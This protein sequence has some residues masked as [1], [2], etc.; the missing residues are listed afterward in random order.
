[1]LIEAPHRPRG[2]HPSSRSDSL[3]TLEVPSSGVGRMTPAGPVAH[4][5]GGQRYRSGFPPVSS[6]RRTD[7]R[8]PLR[9]REAMLAG[10]DH[11]QMFEVQIRR[12][13]THR[14]QGGRHACRYVV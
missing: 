5:P 10:M 7:C 1:M 4:H 14:F 13:D 3:C 9:E 11:H 2:L 6:S 12:Y 8:D